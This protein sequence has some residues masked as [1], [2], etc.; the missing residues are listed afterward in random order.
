MKSKQFI[1]L[2]FM[3]IAFAFSS[4]VYSA[5]IRGEDV[6]QICESW[7]KKSPH[8]KMKETPFVRKSYRL[9]IPEKHRFNRSSMPFY[10]IEM[11]P[12]G[13]VV[14]NSDDR[15][16]PVLA[17]SDTGSLNLDDVPVNAFRSMLK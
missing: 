12:E 10:I 7:M 6:S 1:L 8:F 17:Y 4:F 9:D 11:E 14:M 15:L 13:F 2:V 3:V 16:S 5:P